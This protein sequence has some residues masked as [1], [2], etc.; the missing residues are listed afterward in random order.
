MDGIVKEFNSSGI[1]IA[2]AI[3]SENLINGKAYSYYPT[4]ERLSENIYDQGKLDGTS[5]EFYKSGQIKVEEFFIDGIREGLATWYFENGEIEKYGYYKKGLLEGNY[6]DDWV[7]GSYSIDGSTGSEDL[8][9]LS[10]PYII[11]PEFSF[12]LFGIWGILI[13]LTFFL[14]LIPYIRKRK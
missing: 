12:E 10:S 8:Y 9:P 5:K 13:S 4:G 2:E 1:L 14:I 11:I 3:Y 6:W 7:S